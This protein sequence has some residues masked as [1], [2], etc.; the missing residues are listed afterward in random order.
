MAHHAL[1]LFTD[2]AKQSIKTHVTTYEHYNPDT[3]EAAYDGPK[4]LSIILQTMRP[5]VR[6]DVFNKIGTMKDVILE[7]CDN[8]AVKWISKME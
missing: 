6:V 7:S 1:L 2:A 4:I 8:N 3:G 5:N